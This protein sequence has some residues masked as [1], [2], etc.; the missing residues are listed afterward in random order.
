MENGFKLDEILKLLANDDKTA[1]EKLFNHYYPRLYGFSKS[2]LKWDE[3][4]D[5]ILQ[6]VFL[7]IYQNRKNIRSTETFQ[8]YIF[9][10]TKNLVLNELRSR[11][12]E[13]KARERLFQNSVARE[14]LLSEKLEYLELQEKIGEI[15]RQIPERQQEVYLLSRKDGLSH[16]EI[17]RKLDISEKTVEYHITHALAAIKKNMEEL[18]LLA[19]LYFCFFLK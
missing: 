3:G 16:K 9:T 13:Q 15:I 8:A 18:G 14:Y 12:N 5:D 6:E 2:F 17:A 19:M 7:K 4:I 10:I 1:L 11:L